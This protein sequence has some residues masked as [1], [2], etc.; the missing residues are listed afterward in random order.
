M[1]L[2][3]CGNTSYMFVRGE[4]HNMVVFHA[5]TQLSGRGPSFPSSVLFISLIRSA[6]FHLQL[7][8]SFLKK[9]G[10]DIIVGAVLVSGCKA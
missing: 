5:V 4:S 10:H 6:N 1:S 9:P 7:F 3:T 8:L 2:Q